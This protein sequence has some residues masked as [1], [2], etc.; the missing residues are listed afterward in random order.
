[1]LLF[2]MMLLVLTAALTCSLEARDTGLY[3]AQIDGW[4]GRRD[5]RSER[6]SV[7]S[8]EIRTEKMTIKGSE[9]VGTYMN[10]NMRAT[11]AQHVPWEA[12]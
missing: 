4:R 1:M 3:E 8:I 6:P 2:T 11:T 5:E 10:V 12:H 9:H 7:T